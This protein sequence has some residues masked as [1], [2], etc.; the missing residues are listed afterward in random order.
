MEKAHSATLAVAIGSAIVS[1]LFVSVDL[2]ADN[3][4]DGGTIE[5]RALALAGLSGVIALALG[6]WIKRSAHQE[7]VQLLGSESNAQEWE[8]AHGL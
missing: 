8:R 6:W 1:A 7:R 5:T 3:V 2:L 4:L